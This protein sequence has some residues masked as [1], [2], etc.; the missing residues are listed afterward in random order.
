MPALVGL[1]GTGLADSFDINA[2]S[3]FYFTDCAKGNCAVI[4]INTVGQLIPAVV[5]IA[6]SLMLAVDLLMRRAR[7]SRIE[8]ISFSL[9]SLI[10][11]LEFIFFQKVTPDGI[12]KSTDL[13][14]V[15]WTVLLFGTAL[16]FRGKR[17]FTGTSA[18]SVG[19]LDQTLIV[20]IAFVVIYFV[21]DISGLQQF[22]SFGSKVG[23]IGGGGVADGN[24][25]GPFSMLLAYPLCK[26]PWDLAMSIRR[27]PNR[28]LDY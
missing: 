2:G 22:I 1:S 21:A 3:F 7:F 16:I 8:V 11:L 20:F 27:I 13:G 28:M 9:L 5:A 25:S 19:Y 6:G 4:G 18:K 26:I 10:V 23:Y 12:S 24:F 15:S 17:F 14:V